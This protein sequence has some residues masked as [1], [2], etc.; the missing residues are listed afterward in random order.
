MST[1][2]SLPHVRTTSC[3]YGHGMGTMWPLPRAHTLCAHGLG[4]CVSLKHGLVIVT[5][6]GTMQLHVHS[7]DDGSLVR[8]IGSKGSGK[9]Q[10][11]FVCGGLC[12]SPDG[13]SVLVAEYYN[14]RVQEVNIMDSSWVRFV[15]EGV[16]RQPEFVD[17][18]ADVISVSED[19]HRLSVLSWLDG[20]LLAQFGSYGTGPPG[21]RLL[22]DGSGLV[23][24]DRLNHRLCVFKLNGEFVQAM[25]REEQGLSCPQDVLECNDGFIVANYWAH[26]LMKV[27]A[28]GEVVG[29]YGTEGS[30]N[31]EFNGP[32]A[33][34]ALPDGGLVVRE[35][36]GERF[37]V[38]HGLVLRVDWITACVLLARGGGASLFE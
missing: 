29:V 20:S 38:F 17:C 5:D 32:S 2:L 14:D 11:N 22:V 33:L 30:G 24:A 36:A 12:V 18:N 8:T 23:V 7:L 25:G 34:A 16:L 10:F 4:M 21:V 15:G 1:M 37:Q 28:A 19:C 3:A 9:G 35:C 31:G 6:D 26:N 27:S 13:D